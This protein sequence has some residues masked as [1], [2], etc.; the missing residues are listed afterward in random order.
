MMQAGQQRASQ[1]KRPI[2]LGSSD[3]INR[4][5]MAASSAA[6]DL[7]NKMNAYRRNSVQEYLVWATY[8]NQ[9]QWFELQEGYYVELAANANGVICSH[10]FPRLWLGVEALRSGNLPQVIATLQPGLQ[11]IEHQAFVD[12]LQAVS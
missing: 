4:I 9:I 2:L 1:G 10:V 6:Y 7:N 11:T 8:E 3:R 5:N 12:R